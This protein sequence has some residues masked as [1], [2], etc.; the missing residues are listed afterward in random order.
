ML[1]HFFLG[2]AEALPNKNVVYYTVDGLPVRSAS[3]MDRIIDHVASDPA[4][5][6]VVVSACWA[7]SAMYDWR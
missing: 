3:G 5:K 1:E 2:F 7:C 4:I 6:T